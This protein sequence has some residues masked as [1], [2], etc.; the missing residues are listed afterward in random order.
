LAV[1]EGHVAG[2]EEERLPLC[3]DCLTLL[4]SDPEAFWKL[5]RQRRGQPPAAKAN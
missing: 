2:R 1:S 3:V 4:L 5:L